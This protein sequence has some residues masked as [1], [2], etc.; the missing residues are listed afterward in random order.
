MRALIIVSLL[1]AG[2]AYGQEEIKPELIGGKV[3][4]PADWPASPWIGNCS[5]TIVGPRVLLTAAHCVGNGG[6]TSFSIGPNRYSVVCTHHPSYRGNSTADWALCVS[7]TQI[8]EL[9]YELVAKP[10]EHTC[11]SGKTYLWTGYG[12]TRWGGSI[13][14]RFRTGEVDAVRCPSGTNYDTVTRGSVALCSGDSGGGGYEVIDGVRKVVGVNSRS[15]TT[16]TSY[17]SSTYTDAFHTWA[18]SWSSSKGVKIC[19][20]HDDAPGCRTDGDPDDPDDP[21]EPDCN[22]EVEALQ[23]AVD[24]LKLCL[25]K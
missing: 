13:D 6:S 24:D 17:V 12:C 14:G 21:E 25:Q 10:S 18:M 8:P 23:K 20:L 11:R 3:A 2:Y 4:D 15:N 5:S 9:P 16:D 1:W 22:S 19:G 7:S